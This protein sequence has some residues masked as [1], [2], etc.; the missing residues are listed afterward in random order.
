MSLAIYAVFLGITAILS[1]TFFVYFIKDK[2]KMSLVIGQFSFLSFLYS[3]GLFLQLLAGSEKLA[4]LF[5][6]LS[7]LGAVF[8]LPVFIY[9]I[10]LLSDSLDS[11]RNY[12]LVMF[13]ISLVFLAVIYTND[14]HGLYYKSL[15]VEKVGR[16]Y[17]V[18]KEFGI[19]YY[20]EFIYQMLL[21]VLSSFFIYSIYSRKNKFIKNIAI[22][23]VVIVI[24]LTLLTV[25]RLF[26][27]INTDLLPLVYGIGLFIYL[28]ATHN[29]ILFNFLKTG[30][31]IVPELQTGVVVVNDADEI[32]YFNKNATML[33]PCLT[34]KTIGDSVSSLPL[35][36]IVFDDDLDED[37]IC[38]YKCDDD[39]KYF[40]FKYNALKEGKP[41]DSAYYVFT[42][43]TNHVLLRQKL[44]HLA[45]K[46]GLT[47]IY[48]QMSILKLAEDSFNKAKEAR[49]LFS[50]TILDINNFKVVN[51]MHGHV[52]GNDVLVYVANK[53][54]FYFSESCCN[55]GRFGGDEFLIVCDHCIKDKHKERLNA[56]IKDIT[57]V[58][59]HGDVE[60]ELSISIGTHYV[61]FSQDENAETYLEALEIADKNMYK[62]KAKNKSNA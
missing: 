3:A 57:E 36:Q 48:N 41:S 40:L 46:D 34:K 4:L 45:R 43:Y 61:D 20:I 59:N 6:N 11:K 15:T 39:I 33:M 13:F 32:L 5:F 9:S 62:D 30:H 19:F 42:D 18:V 12:I 10:N 8:I 38:E 51:D 37:F 58:Q 60:L 1:F 50:I 47:Q 29:S 17:T 22:L 25:L 7:S 16:V 31:L 56:L 49:N 26:N 27:V 21:I 35:T 28:Y 53:L 52:F 2:N 23:S 14:F 24:F 44:E 54:S 55:F